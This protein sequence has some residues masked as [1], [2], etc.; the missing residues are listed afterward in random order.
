MNERQL[1]CFLAVATHGTA[2]RAAEELFLGQPTVTYQIKS[3]EKEL[4]AELFDRTQAGLALNDAGR[5]LLPYAQRAAQ[6]MDGGREA[7]R[8][9]SAAAR[10][11]VRVCHCQFIHDVCYGPFVASFSAAHP[12]ANVV[13]AFGQLANEMDWPA[14]D[15]YIVPAKVD[16]RLYPP[17]TKRTLLY[18]A[19]TYAIVAQ[20]HPLAGR[21][22]VSIEDCRPY[23]LVFPNRPFMDRCDNWYW[24]VVHDPSAGYRPEY[25]EEPNVHEMQMS[26]FNSDKIFFSRGIHMNLSA[27]LV[28]IPFTPQTPRLKTMLCRSLAPAN[29]LVGAFA[30]A[31]QAYYREH[32]AE[33]VPEGMGEGGVE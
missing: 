21:R 9:T 15:V 19:W 13:T 6:E 28:Q 29:E 7:V 23:P 16:D 26:V 8:S 1:Q 5:A 27:G 22:G 30:A 24:P 17:R 20:D 2:S 11:T 12:Q 33:F 31:M 3:L 32:A 18:E 4:G 10:E 14:A 25:R